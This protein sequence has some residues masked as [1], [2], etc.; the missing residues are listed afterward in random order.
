MQGKRPIGVP[1]Q[2]IAGW[3]DYTLQSGALRGFGFGGGLR[4][5]GSSYGDAVN[6][7]AYKVPGYLLVDAQVHYD[8]GALSPSLR[9][10]TAA[11]NATNLLD[12]RYVSACASANQCFYGTSRTV[13]AT[14]SYRW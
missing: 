12:N 7:A 1:D 6:S 14:I 13:L 3:G 10:L 4:Y 2:T 8:F 9:G 11:V 5:I